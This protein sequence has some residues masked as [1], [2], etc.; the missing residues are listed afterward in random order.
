M[1]E[2][3]EEM[4]DRAAA[5]IW[6]DRGARMSG[7]WDSRDKREVVVVQTR[8]TALAVITAALL[9]HERQSLRT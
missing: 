9:V 2:I 4:V 5:V 7:T 6:N 3:T 1:I 8:A